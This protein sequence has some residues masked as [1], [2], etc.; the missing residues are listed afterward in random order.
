MEY[1]ARVFGPS[2]PALVVVFIAMLLGSGPGAVA[3]RAQEPAT[4]IGDIVIEGLRKTRESVVRNLFNV[5][6]GDPLGAETISEIEAA[7]VDSDLFAEVAVNAQPR[8]PGTSDIII[9]IDEKWTLIPIPFAASDGSSFSGGLFVIESNLLGLNKQLIGGGFG[10]TSGFNSFFVYVDPALFQSRWTGNLSAG[11]GRGEDERETGAGELVRRFSALQRSI[12]AGIGYRLTDDLE[13]NARIGVQQWQ[14]LDDAAGPA[15]SGGTEIP[16]RGTVFPLELSADWDATRAVDVLRVGPEVGTRVGLVLPDRLP[17]AMLR[18]SLGLSLFDGH[19][20]RLL[21]SGGVGD[22]PPLLERVVSGRD[23]YRT[24]P[25]GSAAADSY[26][27]GS[28]IYDLPV[29]R[30]GWGALVVSHYWELGARSA[31]SIDQEL[32]YGPGGGFRVYLRQ[33]AI[34]ALG[35]D[36]AYNLQ[37]ENLVFSFS[38]G[39]QM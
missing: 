19:R 1:R 13:M 35:L 28:A 24:L 20:I 21:A 15:G 25:F 29:I 30:G 27:S 37:G 4:R 22:L 6:P 39:A 10:G 9:E 23:G 26:G 33:V 32:F 14:E 18:A 31:D 38:L 36:V 16:E 11:V 8:E 7:L 2:A 34:P 12:G 3:V 5:G 17:T